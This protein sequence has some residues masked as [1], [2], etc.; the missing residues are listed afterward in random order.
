MEIPLTST[1][2]Q[3]KVF[4]A[5]QEN[6]T[7]V[8]DLSSSPVTFVKLNTI[9]MSETDSSDE[10]SEQEISSEESEA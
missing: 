8:T 4:D 2:D 5:N 3:I 7:K 1:I 6:Q 9:L 10:S